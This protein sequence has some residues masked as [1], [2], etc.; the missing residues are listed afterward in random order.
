MP[1]KRSYLL[2]LLFLSGAGTLVL[3]VAWFRRMAQIAGATA[4]A[5]GAVLAAV[6]GGMAVG[7]LLFGRRADR[8][9]HPLRLY[10]LLEAGIALAAI[11]TPWLLDASRVAF[12]GLLA[13]F[14]DH[15]AL[16]S[17][18]Q[19]LLATLLLAGPALLM[20]GSLPAIACALRGERDRRG[21]DLGWLYASNTLGAVV[22]TF[23]AGFFLLPTLGLS[24]ATRSAAVL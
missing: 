16:L 24:G 12:D 4:I 2:L 5:M 22:G 15:P 21:R 19:F 10:G 23:A 14:S 9:P 3:E 18:T 11:V 8:S 17:A 20:G 7:A 6:I 13:R 1:T